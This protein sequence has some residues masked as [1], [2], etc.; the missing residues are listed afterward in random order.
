MTQV[1]PTATDALGAQRFVSLTTFK[2]DGSAV[3]TP[4]WVA[5]DGDA[6]VVTTPAD[7]WKVKRLRRNPRVLLV[8][9]GRTGKVRDGDRPVP[10]TA[11]IITDPAVMR[12][13]MRLVR[14]KY[15]L[16]YRVLQL[17]ERVAGG[18]RDRVMLRITPSR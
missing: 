8:P 10:G 13:M 11:T 3:A 9:C 4:V 2:R 5:Q 6:L 17:V 7:S 16:E 12:R 1:H 14:R 15:G 18:R